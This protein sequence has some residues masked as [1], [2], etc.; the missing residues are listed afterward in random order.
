[1][2]DKNTIGLI[3]GVAVLAASG[4]FA[5]TSHHD[6]VET[7]IDPAPAV[8]PA[9]TLI[10]V[11][12]QAAVLPVQRPVTV[13]PPAQHRKYVAPPGGFATATKRVCEP[14]QV[15][16]Q[17]EVQD[18]VQ[19]QEHNNAGMLLGAAA[20][21]LLGHQLGNGSGNTVATIAGAAGGAFAGDRLAN[22]PQ[23]VK[24]TSHFEARTVTTEVCHDEQQAIRTN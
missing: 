6:T 24:P 11:P 20:G 4:T 17:V 23:P 12:V 5:L 21:A 19:Q 7:K 18:E 16:V 9:S 22:K 3:I 8:N 10:P 1:M 2:I 13:Q 15:T 14:Q